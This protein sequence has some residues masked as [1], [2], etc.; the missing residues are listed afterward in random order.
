MAE[1]VAVTKGETDEAL[2]AA[3]AERVLGDV[4]RM[5][6]GEA[7]EEAARM[8]VFKDKSVAEKRAMMEDYTR[9]AEEI[10]NVLLNNPTAKFFKRAYDHERECDTFIVENDH[11]IG[12]FTWDDM[13]EMAK[14]KR[15][16][17]ET[18]ATMIEI[19]EKK[20]FKD[21]DRISSI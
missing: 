8:K 6:L 13:E 20:A 19:A 11:A 18:V 2:G 14:K 12:S 1:D 7:Q 4:G 16:D 5:S 15:K 17:A 21:F 3:Q 10:V 9:E